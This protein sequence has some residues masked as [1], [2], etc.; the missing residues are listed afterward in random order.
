MKV[1]LDTNVL[2]S[3][4][5]AHGLCAELFEYIISHHTLVLSE[6]VLG[7]LERIL[8]SKMNVPRAK[9]HRTILFLREFQIQP[10]SPDIDKGELR[11]EQDKLV[12]QSAIDAKAEYLITGDKDLLTISDRLSS[13]EIMSPRDYWLSQRS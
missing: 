10:A 6:V 7:E 4:F 1:F 2:V 11:D 9:V 5:T 3:A 8:V 13:P 12:L